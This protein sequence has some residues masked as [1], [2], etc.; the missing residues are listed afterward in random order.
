MTTIAN[1]TSCQSCAAMSPLERYCRICGVYE[2]ASIRL[3]IGMYVADNDSRRFGLLC[4][5]CNGK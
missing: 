5:G 3:H 1:P 2:T 4:G